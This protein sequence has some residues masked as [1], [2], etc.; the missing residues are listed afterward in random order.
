MNPMPAIVPAYFAGPE[1]LASAFVSGATATEEGYVALEV[2]GAGMAEGSFEESTLPALV[3]AYQQARAFG[4][5][6]RFEALN[7]A[8]LEAIETDHGKLKEL[9]A[10]YRFPGSNQ[11]RFFSDPEE[12]MPVRDLQQAGAQ[13][14]LGGGAP[15]RKTPAFFFMAAKPDSLPPSLTPRQAKIVR[16]RLEGLSL[17]KIAT[18]LKTK[19]RNV[20]DSLNSILLRLDEATIEN[21]LSVEKGLAEK[22]KANLGRRG[23]MVAKFFAE[24]HRFPSPLGAL[25]RTAGFFSISTSSVRRQLA[26][27]GIHVTGEIQR[28]RIAFDLQVALTLYQ[29]VHQA[30]RDLGVDRTTIRQHRKVVL[31]GKH[32]QGAIELVEGP[33]AKEWWDFE[34]PGVQTG[35]T[36]AFAG[37][38]NLQV[39]DETVAT[40]RQHRKIVLTGKH[41]QGAIELVEGPEAKEWWDFKMPDVQTGGTVAFAGKINLRVRDETVAKDLKLLQRSLKETRRLIYQAHPDRSD[42]HTRAEN[43]EIIRRL[44]Q[45][46]ASLKRAKRRYIEKE[47]AFRERYRLPI[48]K[49]LG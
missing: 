41:L 7:T 49:I 45:Q 8:I 4:N 43:G 39:R 17:A 21:L 12:G 37:K 13:V 14:Y 23:Q 42:N 24:L 48:P 20:A 26:R 31:T 44:M 35:G 6:S 22:R 3:A 15:L 47:L 10:S 11:I 34:M 38:I 36:V 5:R 25:K 30:A 32:L 33:E 19:W 2:L 28:R 1:A 18:R 29:S 40:D 16:L 46:Y 27:A 9:L